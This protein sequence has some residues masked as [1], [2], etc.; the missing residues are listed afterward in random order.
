L[1][2]SGR[3]LIDLESNKSQR[4]WIWIPP[5]VAAIVL[6]SIQLSDTNQWLFLKLNSVASYSGSF[7]WANVT[8]LGDTLVLVVLA[9]PWIRRRPDLI[10]PFVC[11]GIMAFFLSH[12]LKQL[13]PLHRPPN[14]LEPGSF[15]LTGPAYQYQA[16][17]SGHATSV[18]M[19]AAVCIFSVRSN[20][21][22][23]ALFVFATVVGFSRI[24]VGV[25]WP[26]DVIGGLIVG[27][28]S[29]WFAIMLS[30]RFQWGAQKTSQHVFSI[31]LIL[32]AIVLLFFYNTKY[33]QADVFRK[34]IAASMLIYG[35]VAYAGFILS[36]RAN[37]LPNDSS[38]A[39]EKAEIA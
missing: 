31:L 2:E 25:H 34:I 21:M 16:F 38:E 1:S 6:L 28:F 39:V 32:C 24:V 14:L 22:R 26:S 3:P 7:L 29:A 12:G 33:P 8:I 13:V 37:R 18:F 10:W 27:W 23:A 35:L 30:R 5:V 4:C 17:P 15:F 36:K 9:L 11:A 19:M 20:V